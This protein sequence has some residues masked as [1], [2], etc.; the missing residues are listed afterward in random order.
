MFKNELRGKIIND[1]CTLRAQTHSY[2]MDDDSE[3]KKAKGTKMC[4]IKREL[5]FEN[6]KGCLFNDEIILKS[7][8][9]FKSD[10]HIAHTEEVHKIALSSDD[11]KRNKH[12]IGLQHIHTEHRLLKCVKMKWWRWDIFLLKINI[13]CSFYGEIVLKQER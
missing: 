1:F 13:D 8:Q 3:V 12:L 2:L 11:D 6:Y 9:R 4:V 10:H 7:Q 5:M